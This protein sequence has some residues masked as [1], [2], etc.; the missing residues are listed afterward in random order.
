MRIING[1][2]FYMYKNIYNALPSLIP[3]PIFFFQ[4]V[5]NQDDQREMR[6][7]TIKISKKKLNYFNVQVTHRTFFIAYG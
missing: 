4:R 3:P 7:F 6:N 2:D 1:I 5:Y